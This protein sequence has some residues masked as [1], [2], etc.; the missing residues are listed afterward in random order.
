MSTME[1]TFGIILIIL[2]IA[3]VSLVLMQEAQQQN[4][5]AVTGTSDTFFSKNKG[6]T[7]E[8]ALARWTRT[9]AIIFFLLVMAINAYIESG[10]SE[11]PIFPAS[12]ARWRIWLLCRSS[13]LGRRGSVLKMLPCS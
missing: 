11:K 10:M 1:I 6:R 13:F 8:S 7:R 4:V 5:G 12:C 9:V 2:A 3:L